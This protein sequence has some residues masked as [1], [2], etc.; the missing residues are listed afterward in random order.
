[1]P[2]VTVHRV[3][4]GLYHKWKKWFRLKVDSIFK[5]N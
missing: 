5:K 3:A 4:Q 1:M 2:I